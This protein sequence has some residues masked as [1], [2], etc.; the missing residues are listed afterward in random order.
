M[1]LKTHNNGR[2]KDQDS[3]RLD[4][5]RDAVWLLVKLLARDGHD[6]GDV[7]LVLRAMADTIADFDTP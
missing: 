7:V 5:I 6:P 2:D 1:L 3:D 4:E